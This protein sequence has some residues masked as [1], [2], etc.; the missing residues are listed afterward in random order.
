MGGHVLYVYAT[1]ED[2]SARMGFAVGQS[3]PRGPSTDL[4]LFHDKIDA[5]LFAYDKGLRLALEVLILPSAGLGT[6]RGGWPL[7]LIRA[8]RSLRRGEVT[9]ACAHCASLDIVTS[10]RPGAHGTG[11]G[12]TWRMGDPGG[13]EY[14]QCR[15]CQASTD[16]PTTGGGVHDDPVREQPS[17]GVTSSDVDATEVRAHELTAALRDRAVTCAVHW[18]GNSPW[19]VRIPLTDSQDEDAPALYVL[20]EGTQTIVGQANT[21]VWTGQLANFPE[22][23]GDLFDDTLLEWVERHWTGDHVASVADML[24]PLVR[25]LRAGATAFVD[26]LADQGA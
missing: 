18:G 12:R 3:N 4:A 6:C 14:S 11:P 10:I 9:L 24:A 25:L 17:E 2:P 23:G 26:V 22:P 5:H 19:G 7:V 8:H 21:W 13:H 15:E 1:A 16:L 20:T